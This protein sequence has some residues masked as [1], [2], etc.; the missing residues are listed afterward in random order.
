MS[1]LSLLT[2]LSLAPFGRFA[3]LLFKNDR[4]FAVKRWNF[5]I[6]NIDVFDEK[7]PSFLRCL[8]PVSIGGL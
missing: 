3:R 5:F 8:V 4:T 2:P 7:V 1:D 6:E